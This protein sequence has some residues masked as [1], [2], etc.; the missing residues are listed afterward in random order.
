MTEEQLS[1]EEFKKEILKDFKLANQSRQASII[2]RKEV[3]LGKA[4]FGIFGDGQEIPQIAFAKQFKKGD[5]RS[6]Y[7]RDQTFMMAIGEY[8]LLDFF[9]Q[10]YGDTNI[11]H[12]SHNGGR[13]MNNHYASRSLDKDG[14]WKNLMDQKN[15]SSDI[16]PTAGQMP[17]LLGLAYA[18]K[19]FRNVP[20]LKQYK[21]FSNNGNEVAFGTIGD[22]STSE[23]HFWESINAAGVLQVPMALSVWDNGYGISVPKKYQT[24]KE[25]ISDVLAGFQREEGTNG[26]EIFKCKGWDYAALCEMYE[27]GIKICREQ[28]VPVL[29]H[30]DEITQPQGHSTSG[31]HERYKSAERLEWEKEFDGIAR[32]R[33]WII[34][35]GISTNEELEAIEVEALEDVKKARDQA[36]ARYTKPFFELRESLLSII[37]SSTCSCQSMEQVYQYANKLKALQLPYTKD[38][39]STAK[40]ILRFICN[41]CSSTTSLKEHLLIWLKKGEAIGEAMYD[42]CL[43]A[44]EK[45]GFQTEI[46]PEYNADSAMIAGREI[47]RDNFDILFGKYPNLVTF[48]EDTGKIGGVNA[49]LENLQ[50]KYGELR[51]TDTGIRETTIIGQGIGLALRGI[52]PIAEIQ[53]FDYLLYALQTISDDVASTYYR[54]AGGQKVPLIINTRGHRLVGI[55]HAGSPMSMVINAL[56]GM[57]I[58]VPRNMTQAA[59]FYNTLIESNNPALLIEP[60]NGYRLKEKKPSNLGTF[61]I[62]VGLPEIIQE[63]TDI[64]IVTYGANVKIAEDALAN[65]KASGISSELIDVRSMLP[66]D[67]NHLIAASIK[68]TGKVLFFDE[69]VPG[70]GTAYMMQQVL[71]IQDAYKYLDSQPRTLSAKQH[72]PAY[73]ND[74]DYFSKPSAESVF[75]SVYA[76]M[77]EFNPSKY[78]DLY[79]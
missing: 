28:H 20:E 2:G 67:T 49:T 31:S 37:D 68:K 10:L 33:K 22:A 23:G 55:W 69:D 34:E 66:F 56:R 71:E 44:P 16:T 63:G 45:P 5:W 72:R 21:Q 39:V 57:Y 17:R 15:T 14:N 77:R 11:E 19:L 54:T 51:V 38:C 59:G 36:W 70:G 1:Y 13:L 58:L 43:Y 9:A 30:V 64:T 26:I 60:L 25:S 42:T 47:L 50:E 24:T 65:L 18:S 40:N 41:S 12:N 61:K 79:K 48:G 8:S 52:K 74:G 32:T 62:P 3:L 7:Y 35:K 76:I 4:N 75:D 27:K 73:S 53:Y 6:G 29:F 78:S 46:K